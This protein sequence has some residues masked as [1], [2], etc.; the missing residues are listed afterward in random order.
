MAELK[1]TIIHNL[2]ILD[3]FIE[4]RHKNLKK[5]NL[6][7]ILSTVKDTEDYKNLVIDFLENYDTKEEY[8]IHCMGATSQR[9]HVE[10]RLSY[11]R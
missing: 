5:I 9:E 2:D 6:P 7:M 11:F 1:D 3:G 10:G 8:K 4:E